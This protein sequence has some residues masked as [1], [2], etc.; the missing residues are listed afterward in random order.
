[1]WRIFADQKEVD[2]ADPP[3]PRH[4]RSFSMHQEM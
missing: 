2:L 3:H 1:M 4:P